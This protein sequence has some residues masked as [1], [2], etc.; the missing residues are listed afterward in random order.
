MKEIS[1]FDEESEEETKKE[2]HVGSDYVPTTDTED[3]NIERMLDVIGMPGD[4]DEDEYEEAV[5]T[6][7]TSAKK[8]SQESSDEDVGDLHEED[9]LNFN[10]V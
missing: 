8:E 7:G 4:D 3:E 1:E 9:M 10:G 2:E 5:V 6:P